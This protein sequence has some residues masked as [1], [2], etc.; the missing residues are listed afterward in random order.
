MNFIKKFSSTLLNAKSS[1]IRFP[2][3]M[4][5]A[6]ATAVFFSMSID[7][8]ENKQKFYDLLG[9]LFL[10]G[11]FLYTFINLLL[12]GFAYHAADREQL[13][14]TRFVGIGAYLLSIPFLFVVFQTIYVDGKIMR[15][16]EQQYIYFGLIFAFI[17]GC[18][19]ISKI[20]YHKDF[21]AY[22]FN[23]LQSATISIT[24]SLIVYLGVCA[25][26][27]ASVHLL[28]IDFSTAT[29]PKTA[30]FVFLPFNIGVCFSGF[31]K[32]N[33]SFMDYRYPKAFR[34]LLVYLLMPLCA[35]YMGILYL[36]FGKIIVMRSLPQ[37]LIVNLILWYALFSVFYIFFLTRV[38]EYE[39][40]E[41]F[42]N[43][44]SLLML[45]LLTMMFFAIH[46]RV[47]EYGI[48]ENR[49]FVIMGGIWCGL[50]FV[51]YAWYR[52]NSNIVVPILLFFCICVSVIGPFSA[53]S[54]TRESQNRQFIRILESNGMLSGNRI[55]AKSEISR[56]DNQKLSE[57]LNFM[58]KNHKLHELKYLPKDFDLSDEQT[59]NLFGFIPNYHR[60][61]GRISFYNDQNLAIDIKSY[62]KM[63]VVNSLYEQNQ[64]RNEFGDYEIY[65]EGTKVYIGRKEKDKVVPVTVI[66]MQD[67]RD[68]LRVLKEA[69][70]II[71]PEDIAIKGESNGVRYKIVFTELSFSNEDSNEEFFASFYIFTN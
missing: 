39:R 14:Q 32:A 24:Y 33:E 22:V 19:F 61:M 54:V 59:K 6:I 70:S 67:V 27:F 28:G 10:M 21:V 35:I 42:R 31:P 9:Y 18:A 8:P 12:E 47:S 13:K 60:D 16:L 58:A 57:I 44:Y 68:K 3:A 29:Y 63:V 43:F 53:Y 66:N 15:D 49:Y 30:L 34:F 11:I 36:Y 51:Y 46:L 55:V 48:T 17:I 62:T 56:E 52:K 71:N 65:H 26:I 2:V 1:F 5:C 37:G 38:K 23:I 40:V 7:S 4:I 41:K 69:N 45:P 20:F 25:I 50:S 64:G